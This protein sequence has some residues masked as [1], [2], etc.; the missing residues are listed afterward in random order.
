[1]RGEPVAIRRLKRYAMDHVSHE[2]IRAIAG[3]QRSDA[4]SGRSIAI[5]GAGPAG[6]TAAFDL[7][8]NGNRVTVYEALPEAG[9]MMRYGIP[10]YRLPYASIDEDVD[11]IRATGVEIHCNTRIGQDIT[12]DRLKADHDAV[13][14]AIGLQFG[15]STRIPGTDHPDVCSAVDLLR[16]IT[17]G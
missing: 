12:L 1:V 7:A 4:I 10:S 13:L 3:E 11:V 8:R 17:P 16:R 5:V 9:G 2:R 14:L 15:R 6:L